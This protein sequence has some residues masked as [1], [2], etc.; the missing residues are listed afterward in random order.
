MDHRLPLKNFE[1][2]HLGNRK[3]QKG[4]EAEKW[5]GLASALEETTSLKDAWKGR[6]CRSWES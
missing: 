4:F 2:H 3:P 5:H 1:L 6:D